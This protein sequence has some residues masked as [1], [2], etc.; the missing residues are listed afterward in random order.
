MVRTVLEIDSVIVEPPALPAAIVKAG[1]TELR[2]LAPIDA[3]RDR[4][5]ELDEVPLHPADTGLGADLCRDEPPPHGS[6]GVVHDRVKGSSLL[7]NAHRLAT[8]IGRLAEREIVG[9]YDAG[10][11]VASS[12][13]DR[14]NWK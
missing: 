14:R 9:R 7:Q 1:R 2:C 10:C 3:A 13:P 8:G 11:H 6:D 5:I 4:L 12:I